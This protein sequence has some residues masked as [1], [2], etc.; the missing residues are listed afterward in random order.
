MQV[1]PDNAAAV[2]DLLYFSHIK[3]YGFALCVNGCFLSHGSHG[4]AI[5]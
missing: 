2:E 3:W 5:V 4:F 1:T